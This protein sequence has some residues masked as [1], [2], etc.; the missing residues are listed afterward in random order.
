[1]VPVLPA[2]GGLNYICTGSCNNVQKDMRENVGN[3]CHVWVFIW[4]SG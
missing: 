1:L 3:V 4:Y 2:L